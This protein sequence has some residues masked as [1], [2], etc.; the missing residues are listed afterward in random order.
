MSTR[1]PPLS[2]AVCQPTSHASLW[3][4]KFIKDQPMRGAPGSESKKAELVREVADI[5]V[6]RLYAAHYNRWQAALEDLKAR[7]QAAGVGT[8]VWHEATVDGRMV[9]GIGDEGV[10][11]TSITLHHTYGV[12]YIPGSALKGL[13]ARFA[14]DRLGLEWKRG[15]KAHTT[16]FGG[17]TAAGYLTFFDALYVPG[18]GTHGR[19][20]HPDV[21]TVHHR[22]YYGSGAAASNDHAPADWNSPTPVPFLSA[23]GRYLLALGG[24]DIWVA[25]MLRILATALAEMGVGAKT[26]SGYGRMTVDGVDVLQTTNEAPSDAQPV[27]AGGADTGSS[28][29]PPA[30]QPLGTSLAPPVMGH[31]TYPLADQIDAMRTQRIKGEIGNFVPRWRAL[32]DAAAWHAVAQALLAKLQTLN[33]WRWVEGRSWWPELRDYL[34]SHDKE[35]SA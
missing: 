3:L 2:A 5:A 4:E 26:S 28:A 31:Q 14:A 7:L 25:Y 13:A 10:L 32:E 1:R 33:E 9:V 30:S 11:E 22:D 15:G 27:V 29:A 12:P 19:A 34:A 20:L 17:T 18:T 35:T 6:S 16:A 23:T 8:V 24:P 21:L